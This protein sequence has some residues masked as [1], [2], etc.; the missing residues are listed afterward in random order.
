MYLH[1][2]QDAMIH[3]R[4]IVG[5]FD[6]DTASV[7]KRTRAF[8]ARAEKQKQVVYTSTELPKS[9]VVAAAKGRTVVYVSQLSSA[10]LKGR[11]QLLDKNHF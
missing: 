10:T 9:F 6:L 7:S 2:G 3:T 11:A 8:L 1:L 5:V 4:D